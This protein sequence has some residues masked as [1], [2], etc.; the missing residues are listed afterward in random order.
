[1]VY[2]C[3]VRFRSD[4]LL[5]WPHSFSIEQKVVGVTK[6]TRMLTPNRSR[7]LFYSGV[8]D[9]GCTSRSKLLYVSV[10]RRRSVGRLYSRRRRLCHS[11]IIRD[12]YDYIPHDMMMMLFFINNNHHHHILL[13]CCMFFLFNKKNNNNN[14]I[15]RSVY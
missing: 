1:M 5:F 10:Y 7:F 4:I 12:D 6:Q 15:Y 13:Y 8:G 14:N 11:F 9:E 3:C 2:Y